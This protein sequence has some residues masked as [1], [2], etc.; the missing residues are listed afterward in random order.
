VCVRVCD[1]PSRVQLRKLTQRAHACDRAMECV[2]RPHIR[3]PTMPAISCLPKPLLT[4]TKI[5]FF[6]VR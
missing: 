1:S 4:L 3:T 6:H 2:V 5:I